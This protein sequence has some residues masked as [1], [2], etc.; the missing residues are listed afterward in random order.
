[1]SQILKVNITYDDANTIVP[2]GMT[3][4]GGMN[5]NV[6]TLVESGSTIVPPGE[7]VI[8]VNESE[9]I[10]Y[11]ATGCFV[12]IRNGGL[13]DKL[14]LQNSITAT[15]SSGITTAW[16]KTGKLKQ[17]EFVWLNLSGPNDSGSLT[18]RGIKVTN[19]DTID[20]TV[21]FSIFSR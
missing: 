16:I 6:G 1:M 20:S 5:L 14:M 19:T 11:N 17:G 10:N 9:D 18:P 15:E 2:D 8:L 4:N 7:S 21:E 13:G 3:Y 12:F